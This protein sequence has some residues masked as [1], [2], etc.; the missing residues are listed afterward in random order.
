MHISTKVIEPF[1][2]SRLPEKI[3]EHPRHAGTGSP[4]CIRG[5]YLRKTSHGQGT[6]WY[7]CWH[8][9]TLCVRIIT[10]CLCTT[11]N[12]Y[13]YCQSWRQDWHPGWSDAREQDRFRKPA[14]PG[15]LRPLQTNYNHISPGH[16][17][18]Y[19]C[20]IWVWIS[21]AVYLITIKFP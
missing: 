5:R 16:F 20:Q 9:Q 3:W 4:H 1:L 11:G 13:H 14:H 18:V 10:C 2:G 19:V 8:S 15:P 21:N 6:D 12:G 7:A 17:Y